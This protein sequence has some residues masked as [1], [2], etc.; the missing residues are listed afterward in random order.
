MYL[1]HL[2]KFDI[3]C[4]IFDIFFD[5]HISQNYHSLYTRYAANIKQQNTIYNIFKDISISNSN[6]NRC[7]K[8]LTSFSRS[9]LSFVF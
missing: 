3:F 8:I 6:S 2:I 5:I 9:L 7:A 1:I 4:D